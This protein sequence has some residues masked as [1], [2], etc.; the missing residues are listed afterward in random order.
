MKTQ[1]ERRCTLLESPHDGRGHRGREG[2]PRGPQARGG[3]FLLSS[4]FEDRLGCGRW[5]LLPFA[6]AGR[7]RR[8][9][10]RTGSTR[11]D[12]GRRLAMDP[13]STFAP[14]PWGPRRPRSA[15]FRPSSR[16]VP[17]R[18]PAESPKTPRPRMTRF[19]DSDVF[20]WDEM[21]TSWRSFAIRLRRA[22][23]RPP[24][25]CMPFGHPRSRVGTPASAPS[26]LGRSPR[27]CLA[28]A[29]PAW[30]VA[31]ATKRRHKPP[32]TPD[33]PLSR[34]LLDPWE[35][36]REIA[37]WALA[38]LRVSLV[39]AGVV[40]LLILIVMA[41]RRLRDRQLRASA[42]RIRILPP[43]DLAGAPGSEMFWMSVHSLLR[44]WWRRALFGQ[45]HLVWE[46]VARPEHVEIS[47]WVPAEVPTG[48][49]ERALEA[50]WP[51]S[52]AI[53]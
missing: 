5:L 53:D 23:A 42:R 16:R 47:I 27:W 45:P 31:L 8:S 37:E 51:G 20:V 52:R 18:L 26:W 14:R 6:V 12:P 7:A 34:F 11:R 15:E 48:I 17:G 21:S 50:A 36:L 4:P 1:Y 28:M 25:A 39:A 3:D 46:V 38:A 13:A 29:A 9:G 49:V 43:P 22:L 19:G 40:L 44:P 10:G 30:L 2:S 35:V 41:I 32:R 33:G 24:G